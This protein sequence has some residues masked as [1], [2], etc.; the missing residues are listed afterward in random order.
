MLLEQEDHLPIVSMQLVFN[1]GGAIND[2]ELP[3]LAVMAANLLEE[4]TQ[5]LGAVAFARKLDERA[6]ELNINAGRETLVF[7]ITALKEQFEPALELLL[8]LLSDPNLTPEALDKVQN[9]TIGTLQRKESDFDYVASRGLSALLYK[10]TPL[11]YPT[12][13][14]LKTVP[15]ITLKAV[16]AHLKEVMVQQRAIVLFGGDLSS[17]QAMQWGE[18]LLGTI[19]SGEAKALPRYEASQKAHE[20]EIKRDTQQ[21]Y[22]YFGSPFYRKAGDEESYKASI[23][24]FILGSSG[25]GSRLMEEIR[26]KRGYAYSAYGRISLGLTTSSFRGHLQTKPE[27]QEAAIALVREVIADFVKEGATQK[28]LDEA[29]QFLL[30]AE[31]LRNETMSQRLSRAFNDFYRG[32]PQGWS[33]AQLEKIEALT[34]EELN[35]FIREHGEILNLSFFVLTR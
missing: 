22:I 19:G 2:G 21:A 31:P 5:K 27:N 35:T 16:E 14:T 10:D 15:K 28:E 26:V 7:E 32:K 25:F 24:A 17:D 3:G 20:K 1:H 9:R 23:A 6:I 34:L 18:K 29:R 11:A 13:G 12:S 8:E 33:Q 30:G 4:G